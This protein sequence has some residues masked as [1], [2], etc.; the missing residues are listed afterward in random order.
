[1][2][3]PYFLFLFFR[4]SNRKFF[5]F[6][7]FHK[8]TRVQILAAAELLSESPLNP[9]QSSFLQTV[10]ACGTSLVE[11]VNHVLD[12]TKLSGGGKA[13][14]VDHVIVPTRFV[15][16]L[17]V[18]FLFFFFWRLIVFCDL[19]NDSVDLMQLV[20]EAVDGCWIGFRA[21]S[22][23]TGDGIGS[24]YSPPRDGKESPVATTRTRH[25][26]TVVDIGYRREVNF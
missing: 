7:F 8:Y 20:E 11:T 12:F 5:S 24:V 10:Q 13:G 21:R 19:V 22:A 6:Y 25:V 14:G 18:D 3:E 23:I 16:L 26:E 17:S 9:S 4:I 2:V 15:F 1:V